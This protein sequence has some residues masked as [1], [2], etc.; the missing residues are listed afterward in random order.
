MFALQKLMTVPEEVRDRSWVLEALQEAVELEFSTVPPYLYAMWSIDPDR[1]PDK[2][3]SVLRRIAV[4]EM[5]HM[6]LACNLLAGLGVTPLIASRVPVYPSKLKAGVHADLTV[7]LEP[8]ARPLLLAAFMV[9]E[10][11]E[12]IVAEEKDFQPTGDKLISTFY[13]AI[14]EAIS[15]DGLSFD[16]ANQIDLSSFFFDGLVPV[17]VTTAAEA[18][19]TIDFILQQGEGSGGSPFEADPD[20]PSHFYAF[21]ELFHEPQAHEDATLHLHR[22]YGPDAGPS[23]DG[24]QP[25]AWAR[26][27]RFQPS[28]LRHAPP[29]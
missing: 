2:A 1:D 13:K 12:K 9:I 11:P 6:G 16:P 19:A 10:E 4:Q 3:A 8:L 17:P 23:P 14:Q 25:G 28:V 5:L 26:P 15:K 22:H 24:Q 29:A 18:N 7:G 20:N 21:G 27:S